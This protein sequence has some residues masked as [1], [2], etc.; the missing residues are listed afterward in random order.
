MHWTWKNC[1]KAWHE[2]YCGKSKD[3]TIVLEAIA[4]QDLWIWHYF[5]GLPETLNDINVL[6]RSPLFTKL[7]NGEARLLWWVSLVGCI[8]FWY[9]GLGCKWAGL[10]GFG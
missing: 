9:V 6:Q 8:P 4:S 1:P 10:I 5:F 2:Q 3:A 7:A